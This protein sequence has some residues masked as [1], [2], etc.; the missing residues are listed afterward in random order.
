MRG[1]INTR[2]K[3]SFFATR[4]DSDFI[5]V[6]LFPVLVGLVIPYL[7]IGVISSG[8]VIQ[9]MT[10]GLAPDLSWFQSFQPD[11]SI[12]PATHGGVPPWLGSLLICLVVLT[13]VFYGGMRGTAW[14]N[15]FQ[16][17]IFMILGVVTFLCDCKSIGR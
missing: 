8:G 10:A 11:Q 12:N 7:L 2:P 1:N 14:A 4:L 5:G 13:Y 15:A 16:T 3:L 9:A 17:A 6:L